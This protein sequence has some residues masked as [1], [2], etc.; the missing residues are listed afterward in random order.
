MNLVRALRTP[1][2]TQAHRTYNR[3]TGG[4][5]RQCTI[6][7]PPTLYGRGF[8]TTAEHV[9]EDA[10]SEDKEERDW[11][12]TDPRDIEDSP[13]TVKDKHI[14][15]LEQKVTEMKSSWMS[16]LAD[17]DN[18][19]KK[20]QKDIAQTRE[21]STDKM[22]ASLF[23]ISDTLDFCLKHKPNFESDEFK[24]NIQA[25]GAFDGLDAAK[26]QFVSA[27]KSINIDEIV[28]EIGDEFD[29]LIH[30]ACFEVEKGANP[31]QIGLVI[32]AGWAKD[33]TLLRPADVGVVK[34]A[35]VPPVVPPQGGQQEEA[36]SEWSEDTPSDS[37]D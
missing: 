22:A 32:K 23:P 1:R 29:P 21:S 7:Q 12:K 33:K 3:Y 9:K 19:T 24:D 28:P 31:G 18:L 20:M 15:T 2:S 16:T 35:P 4:L 26:K 37:T 17:T 11:D 34:L 5:D 13:E 6:G 36:D 27:L 25:K 8:S 14:F 10:L 30:N